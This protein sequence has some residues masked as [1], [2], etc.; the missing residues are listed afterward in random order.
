MHGV[1]ITFTLAFEWNRG[2]YDVPGL[3]DLYAELLYFVVPLM[4]VSAVGSSPGRAL[5]SVWAGGH[6]GTSNRP[7]HVGV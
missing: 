7:R 2:S 6:R 4:K 3:S 5:S 1:L